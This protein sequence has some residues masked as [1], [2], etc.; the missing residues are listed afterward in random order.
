MSTEDPEP[1][2]FTLCK[3]CAK[4]VSIAFEQTLCDNISTTQPCPRCATRIDVWVRIP[5]SK[6]S[7]DATQG[8]E[9]QKLV[10]YLSTLSFDKRVA[11]FTC[12][13]QCFMK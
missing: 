8:D 11:I 3:N 10:D 4:E 12:L 9:A 13:I 6:V 7:V 1:T 2:A 5:R